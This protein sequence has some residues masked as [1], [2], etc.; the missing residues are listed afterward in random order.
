MMTILLAI[1]DDG[2]RAHAMQHLAQLPVRVLEPKRAAQALGAFGSI[3]ID[4]MMVSRDSTE[5][6][7]SFV[8]SCKSAQPDVLTVGILGK[9]NSASVS[10]VDFHVAE[11][12]DISDL[13]DI[14]RT[15]QIG[16][17]KNPAYVSIFKSINE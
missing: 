14:L 4:V 11:S 13:R 3:L 12:F 16:R 6:T 9:N 2:A 7:D 10:H 15:V 5:F 17:A 1:Q 8:A